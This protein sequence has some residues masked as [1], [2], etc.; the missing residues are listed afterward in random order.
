MKQFFLS[1]KA[2]VG[3]AFSRFFYSRPAAKRVLLVTLLWL[4]SMLVDLVLGQ[5]FA[6][7]LW[8]LMLV[9]LLLGMGAERAALE[10]D[11]FFSLPP[12]KSFAFWRWQPLERKRFIAAVASLATGSV[13][14][15]IWGLFA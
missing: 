14:S 10:W 7:P 4:P 5:A 9:T 3:G 13:G 11:P 1:V 6:A 2:A 12:L 15:F 8:A